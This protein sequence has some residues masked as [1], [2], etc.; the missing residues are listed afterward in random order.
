MGL[1]DL[2]DRT[3]VLHAL[4]EFDALGRE[5]FL[6]RTASITL[7]GY[8]LVHEGKRYDSKAIAGVAYKYE[9]GGPLHAKDF[10]GG[11]ATVARSSG[12]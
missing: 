11:A 12:A 1:G 5:E 10:N 9:H 8:F 7:C 2:T 6:S 4:E 3:A